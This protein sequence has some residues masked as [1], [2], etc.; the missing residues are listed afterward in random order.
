MTMHATERDCRRR[1][2]RRLQPGWR[3]LPTCDCCCGVGEEEAMTM[4]A[5][6]RLR[7]HRDVGHR[8]RLLVMGDCRCE[9]GEVKEGSQGW[10]WWTT[11]QKRLMDDALWLGGQKGSHHRHRWRRKPCVRALGRDQG[12]MVVAAFLETKTDGPR[13]GTAEGDPLETWG[14]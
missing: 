11:V 1:D 7:H 3:S 8:W 5:T 9:D 6:E 12:S 13:G 14:T 2:V 10:N 4:H